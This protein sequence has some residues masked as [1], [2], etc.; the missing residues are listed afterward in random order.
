MLVGLVKFLAFFGIFL[1]GMF[2]QYNLIFPG[3]TYEFIPG[4]E[5]AEMIYKLSLINN[6][7]YIAMSIIILYFVQ[8]YAVYK[9]DRN[10]SIYWKFKKLKDRVNANE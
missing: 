6:V 4:Q 9:T 7:R 1:G 10:D 8:Q 2:A 5:P 3:D